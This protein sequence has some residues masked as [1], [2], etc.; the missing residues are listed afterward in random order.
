MNDFIRVASCASRLRI[1]APKSRSLTTVPISTAEHG[2]LLS[3]NTRTQRRF[4]KNASAHFR[5]PKVSQQPLGRR[6]FSDELLHFHLERIW[7]SKAKAASSGLGHI[8][9]RAAKKMVLG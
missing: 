3:G 1:S 8:F 5:L 9:G 7:D 2:Y 6:P 4:V